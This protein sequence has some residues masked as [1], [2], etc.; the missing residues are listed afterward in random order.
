MDNKVRFHKHQIA[1]AFNKA[2]SA[3]NNASFLQKEVGLRLLERLMYMKIAPKHILDLG[4]GTG[5]LSEQLETIYP[6]ASIV[7]LDLAHAMLCEH[8]TSHTLKCCADFDALPFALGQFDLIIANCALQW[9]NNLAVTTAQIKEVMKPNAIFIFSTFGP[10]T[11]QEL[12]YIWGNIDSYQ[13]VN[14][15]IDMH[16]IG[17]ILLQH[18]FIDPVVDRENITVTY[19]SAIKLMKELKSMGATNINSG[20]T[21]YL[22]TKSSIAKVNEDYNNSFKTADEKNVYATFEIIYGLSWGVRPKDEAHKT[23]HIPVDTIKNISI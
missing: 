17:D 3:Y 10:D 4:G 20:R 6:N 2:A 16:H 11:L 18:K 9:S 7:N 23:Q 22:A 21:K 19:P 13:H 12:K 5:Q 15:F 8:K 14:D 1:R